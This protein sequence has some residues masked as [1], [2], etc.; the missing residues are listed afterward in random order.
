MLFSFGPNVLESE[1]E[2][3]LYYKFFAGYYLNELVPGWEERLQRF[4]AL[5]QAPPDHKTPSFSRP[6]VL[7]PEST[8]VSFDCHAYL[9][10][11]TSDRGEFADIMLHDVESKCLIAIEAKF[12]SDWNFAKDIEG[13]AKRLSKL[14]K[15][16]PIDTQIVQCLLV[17]QRKW[18]SAKVMMKHPESNCDKLSK[19][20]NDVVRLFWDSLIAECTDVNVRN[21][22]NQHIRRGRENF[23]LTLR[24]TE[25]LHNLYER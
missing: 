12:L 3:N 19:A 5:L 25:D 8:H 21:Y 20:D 7:S 6:I 18:D 4:A 14:R 9:V 24:S 1:K 15:Y 10:D 16:L 13:N 11:P 23:R 22:F 17:T 2:R